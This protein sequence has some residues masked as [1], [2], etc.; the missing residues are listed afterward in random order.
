MAGS[1]ESRSSPLRRDRSNVR[2]HFL[3]HVHACQKLDTFERI[4][5]PLPVAACGSHPFVRAPTTAGVGME[6]LMPRQC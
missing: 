5:Q 1:T 4:S 6:P 2:Q 3:C